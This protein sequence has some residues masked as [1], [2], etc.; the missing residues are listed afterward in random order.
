MLFDLTPDLQKNIN[1][2]HQFGEHYMVVTMPWV[3]ASRVAS[4]HVS[5]LWFAPAGTI[6]MA[7]AAH[8]APYC[9][10]LL[11]METGPRSPLRLVS[12]F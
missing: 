12:T 3:P 11:S 1:L 6:R 4:L 10:G 8:L 7:N 2:A 9:N 5:A